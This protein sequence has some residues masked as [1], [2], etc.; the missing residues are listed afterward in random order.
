MILTKAKEF[1]KDLPLILTGDFNVDEKDEAYFTLA[2]SKVVTD[3]HD[4][5]PLKYEPNSSF[6]GWGKSLR[7]S[8]RID[9]IFITKPFQTK[10]Y[11]ILTDTYMSKF[12]SDHFPVVTTLSWK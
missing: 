12:P 8:G 7:A 5:S 2:N 10:K 1:A 11:G 6:N 9:H 3:V 4:L